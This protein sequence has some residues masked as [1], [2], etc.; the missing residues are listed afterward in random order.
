[1]HHLGDPGQSAHPPLELLHRA[2]PGRDGGGGA[3]GGAAGGTPG[4]GTERTG[5]RAEGHRPAAFRARHAFA[6]YVALTGVNPTTALYFAAL[7]T[8]QGSRLAT[9]PAAAAFAG[10]VLLASL[11]WQQLLAAVGSFA[12]S[13]IPD[14]AR[15]WTFRLGHGLIAV[16]A[17]RIALP[18]P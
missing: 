8:A 10:G 14:S 2:A 7:I 4:S 6:R 15:T 5:A 3:A 13:R 16:Y 12:G 17:V 1:M 11:L 18:L 9:V